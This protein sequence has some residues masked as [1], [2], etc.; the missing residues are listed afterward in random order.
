MGIARTLRVA[1]SNLV[2]R[3]HRNARSSCT[4]RSRAGVVKGAEGERSGPLTSPS[5]KADTELVVRIRSIVDERLSYG[6]R[7][8]TAVLNRGLCGRRVNHK[9]VYRVMK[10]NQLLLERCTGKQPGRVHDGV[11]IT[12]ASNTR[13]CS[14]AFTTRCWNGDVVEIA[15]CLDCCDR[16]IIAYVAVV[17][18][19]CGEQIHRDLAAVL[20]DRAAQDALGGARTHCR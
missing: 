2:E 9:R 3:L 15:F 6:Y 4:V 8:V 16:E 11:I 12:A 7:R 14:D 18:F 1:R 20:R 17:G 19:L 13:W 5:T 10:D